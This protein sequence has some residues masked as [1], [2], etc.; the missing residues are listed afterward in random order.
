MT[1]C[2]KPTCVFINGPAFGANNFTFE[3]EGVEL[4]DS[5]VDSVPQLGIK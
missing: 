2:T 3:L 1:A 4:L 5:N